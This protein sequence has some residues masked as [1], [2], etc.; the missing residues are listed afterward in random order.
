MGVLGRV[1]E[2]LAAT[3]WPA[4]GLQEKEVEPLP[5]SALRGT[6]RCLWGARLEGETQPPPFGEPRSCSRQGRPVWGAAG[7]SQAPRCGW[8][9]VESRV[10]RGLQKV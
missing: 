6:G 5:L 7:D 4:K 2:A 8:C 1:P 9:A 10:E 3:L